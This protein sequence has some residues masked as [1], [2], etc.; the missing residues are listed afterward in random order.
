MEDICIHN[1]IYIIE[2]F[3]EANEWVKSHTANLASL[4]K[5]SNVLINN[6][7]QKNL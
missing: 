3:L 1:S 4:K 6:I 7:W 2:Y 5:N